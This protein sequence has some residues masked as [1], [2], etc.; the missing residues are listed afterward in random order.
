ML[1][2]FGML[3]GF[4]TCL[5]MSQAK[6]QSQ[7]RIYRSKLVILEILRNEYAINGG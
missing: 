6:V 2:N 7:W 3:P 4:S 5:M 1:S